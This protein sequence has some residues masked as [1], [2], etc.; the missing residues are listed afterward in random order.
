[1]FQY[2]QSLITVLFFITVG[3]IAK[4]IHVLDNEIGKRIVK[5]LFTI[6]LPIAVF[7]S[8]ASNTIDFHYLSLPIIAILLSSTLLC[9]SYIVGKILHLERKTLGTLI[10]A[11]GISSTLL[12]AL[13][14]ISAFYGLENTKYLYLYDFGNG[15][16]AWTLIYYIAG[17]YGNKKG[18]SILSSLA[19][20]IH[21]P[22]LW[23]LLLGI[24]ASMLHI[25][26]P[27]IFQKFT[28]AISGFTNPMLLICVGLFLNFDF[29]KNK[30]NVSR[31]I[32]SAIIVMGVSYLI[33]IALTNL[34]HITGI[35]QKIV[36][37]CAIA[38]AGSLTVAF[39]AE[40]DLDLEFAS[41]L[42]A[43]TMTIAIAFVPIFLLT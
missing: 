31:L 21:T 29:F 22:M 36:Y 13:P 10:V 1:M 42:V 39:S 32:I 7:L 15:L 33:A 17:L 34:F 16:L 24:S 8:F 37:L 41:A 9:I 19:T 2:F 25:P 6:P 11:A 3:Y 12:F 14:F 38:P 23:A 4:S 20:F 35:I 27:I 43:F 40:H 28:T 26:F 18:K 5:F 30:K